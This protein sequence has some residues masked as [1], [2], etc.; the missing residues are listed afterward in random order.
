MICQ[1]YCDLRSEQ[2]LAW[3]C[4]VEHPRRQIA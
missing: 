1:G 3:I 4:V 2:A